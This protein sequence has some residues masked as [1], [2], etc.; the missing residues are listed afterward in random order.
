[1]S[2]GQINH[3]LRLKEKRMINR[4]SLLSILLILL[5][6]VCVVLFVV[7]FM[8]ANIWNYGYN[9]AVLGFDTW[10]LL[11]SG[12]I[13]FSILLNLILYFHFGNFD[14]KRKKAER[15]KPEFIDGKRVHELTFPKGSEGGIFSKTYIKVDEN[16]LLRIR[17]LMVEPTELWETFEEISEGE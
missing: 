4:Y 5:T 10:I 11:L 3:D 16:N 8:G 15:P 14:K 9:W 17:L 1:M 12:L 7:I 2:K 13:A 6:I